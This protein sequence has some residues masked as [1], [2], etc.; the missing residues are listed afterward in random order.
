MACDFYSLIWRG[1]SACNMH[2][3]ADSALYLWNFFN[4]FIAFVDYDKNHNS[5]LENNAF[6]YLLYFFIDIF[7]LVI[8]YLVGLY[9]MQTKK[10]DK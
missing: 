4:C 9:L 10:V 5:K 1:E 8:V 2:I 7:L 6:I 3:E